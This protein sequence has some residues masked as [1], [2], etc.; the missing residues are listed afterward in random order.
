MYK[1]AIIDDEQDILDIL[2]RSL[3][4]NKELD[5]TI[6]NNPIEGMSSVQNGNF[7]LVLLDIMMPTLNGM[8][9]LKTLHK[10]NPDIKVIIMT[11][12]D[13]LDKSITAHKFN[14]ANYLTKPFSSLEVVS[15]KIMK[16]LA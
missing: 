14:A 1:I 5:I 16:A 13:T 3:Q 9:I 8:D 11:A 12:F 10:T 2:N 15:Q 4:R 6:F 7:D